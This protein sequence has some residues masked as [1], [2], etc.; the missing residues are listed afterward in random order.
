MF[1]GLKQSKKTFLEGESQILNMDFKP[2][3]C[4]E[5]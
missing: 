1:K 3:F 4:L 5:L 2:I